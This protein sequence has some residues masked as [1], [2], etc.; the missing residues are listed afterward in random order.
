MQVEKIGRNR[1]DVNTYIVYNENAEEAI[2][3]DPA[4][5]LALINAFI[6]EKNL[7]PIAILLTHGH[8]DHI[9]DTLPLKEKY[10]IDIYAH[11]IENEM[12]MRSEY[13]LAGHFGYGDLHF[14]ADHLFRDNDVLTIG[15]F[16]FTVLHTPGHTKGG[17]CF[18]TG[19]IMFTGDTLFYGSMGRT[20]LYGGS[21]EQMRSSLYR[22]SQYGDHIVV[23]PGHGSS[24]TIGDEK[25]LNSFIKSL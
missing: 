12:L 2:I 10:G 3:I 9:A 25:K 15:P 23:H 16:S 18:L 6:E 20:D 17:V 21:D 13:N 14:S 7:K 5:N 11:K 4:I 8:I 1:F 22:L 24:T 19:D